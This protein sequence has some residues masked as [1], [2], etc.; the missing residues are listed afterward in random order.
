MRDHGDGAVA[1]GDQKQLSINPAGDD[2]QAVWE[3][4]PRGSRSQFVTETAGPGPRVS[5]VAAAIRDATR[6]FIAAVTSIDPVEPPPGPAR[7]TTLRVHPLHDAE[8]GRRQCW[9]AAIWRYESSD[10]YHELNPRLVSATTDLIQRTMAITRDLVSSEDAS[11]A[12]LDIRRAR[13]RPTVVTRML[14]ECDPGIGGWMSRLP[15]APCLQPA[16]HPWRDR[17]MVIWDSDAQ[18]VREMATTPALRALMGGCNDGRA[19]RERAAWERMIV[20]ALVDERAWHGATLRMVS[21][22]T[23][24]GE[25]VVDAGLAATRDGAGRVEV[26]GVDIDR[27][28]LR[29]AEHLA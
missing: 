13:K 29:I 1:E 19:V 4:V 14:A 18:G 2:H 22:G 5:Q 21:L 10:P 28:S 7:E 6:R 8:V 17:G 3:S 9:P 12:Y 24:T 16:A 11:L 15:F 25:P 23:G 20:A 27:D 26:L